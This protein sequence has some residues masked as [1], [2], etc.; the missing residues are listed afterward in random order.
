VDGG[1][2]KTDYILYK[3][4]YPVSRLCWTLPWYYEWYG[5]ETVQAVRD[6][7]T[8]VVIYKLNPNVWKVQDFATEMDALILSDYKR[9]GELNL[10][11]RM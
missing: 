3:R 7:Q 11:E 1:L 2:L 5:K 10:Y 9:V 8:K 6:N 4:R